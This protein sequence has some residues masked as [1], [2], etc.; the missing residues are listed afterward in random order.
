MQRLKSMGCQGAGG[1]WAQTD[2]KRLTCISS[3]IVSISADWLYFRYW[4]TSIL[5]VCVCEKEREKR[6]REREKK[7][8]MTI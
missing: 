6:E 1:P 2:H 5:I 3:Q 7:L 4:Q 8:N